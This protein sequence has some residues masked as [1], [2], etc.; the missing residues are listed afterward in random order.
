MHM[1]SLLKTHVKESYVQKCDFMFPLRVKPPM[2]ECGINAGVA[3]FSAE[4]DV[5]GLLL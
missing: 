2:H 1:R 4:N 3:G 5:Y